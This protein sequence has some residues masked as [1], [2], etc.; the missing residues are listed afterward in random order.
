MQ[1]DKEF[2]SKIIKFTTDLSEFE[3]CDDDDYDEFEDWE[4]DH[5]L[6][7]KK[8]YQGLLRY[9]KERAKK[10]PD[11][12]NAQYHLGEAYVLNGEYEKAILF[13]SVHHKNDPDNPNFKHV[14]LDALF[15]LGKSENDFKWVRKPKVLRMNQEILDKCYEYLRSKRKPRHIGELYNDFMSDGYLLFKEDDLL[16]AI[17]EDKRFIVDNSKDGIFAEVKVTRKTTDHKP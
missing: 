13:L 10:F 3:V 14:I 1:N 2:K 11:D 8:D 17:V 16:K 9:R 15:A 6:L 5:D 12:P 4:V 7:E